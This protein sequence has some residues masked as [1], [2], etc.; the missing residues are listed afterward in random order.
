MHQ[1]QV[2]LFSVIFSE[3]SNLV[4]ILRCS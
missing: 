4:D 3:A 2:N 1:Y